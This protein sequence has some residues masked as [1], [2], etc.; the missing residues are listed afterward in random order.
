MASLG[1]VLIDAF[2]TPPRPSGTISA[3]STSRP[4]LRS[5]ASYTQPTVPS[6]PDPCP[7][8]S[9]ATSSSAATAASSQSHP[10][11]P[12]TPRESPQDS[13]VL[14]SQPP[15]ASAAYA[16]STFPFPPP[17]PS[18]HP[19]RVALP[20]ADSD[21]SNLRSTPS[22]N[23]AP[24]STAPPS[25]ALT[26]QLSFSSPPPSP[27]DVYET[28]GG[29]A[30]YA[31]IGARLWLAAQ[32]LGT[33]V[34][35][36]RKRSDG[37]GGDVP[38]RLERDLEVYGGDMWVWNE[39]EGTKMTRARIRYEGDVRLYQHIVKAPYRSLSSLLPTPLANAEYLHV[40]P[41]YSPQDLHALLVELEAHNGD[42]TP[43]ET[44]REGNDVSVGPNPT[45]SWRPKIVFEPT[46][47]SCHAGQ[48]EWLE[49]ILSGIEVLSPNHEELLSFYSIPPIPLTDP[50]L[51][52]TIERIIS[53]LL[54][55]GVGADG[56]GAVVV[57]CGKL[58]AVVG[59]RKAGLRWFPAYWAGE[60]E[61]RVKDVTGAGNA[62]LGGYIAGLSHSSGDPY[63]AALYATVSASFVV[64]QMGLPVLLTPSPTPR[65]T[66]E[67]GNQS[68]SSGSERWNGDS[69]WNR[70]EA[71]RARL[72]LA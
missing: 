67:Q 60:D 63:E 20:R 66:A 48:K 44:R 33:L 46:P 35:R 49:R 39:G 16:S 50:T 14:T 27:A 6:S 21:P 13:P 65:P 37:S 8:P 30:L 23:L 58:G 47:P 34:N 19:P 38:Q 4:V 54:H 59:T 5:P 29:G 15:P 1:T 72:D 52:P 55:L 51:R 9:H 61:S 68:P 62:F 26:P 11:L 69:P 45:S 40:A 31:L 12:P 57:R 22:S 42:P 36:E 3:S 56:Q 10:S 71:L 43:T 41:P 7:D 17:V 24:A 64:E 28:L 18:F 25:G 53:H 70:L 2:D 32:Q